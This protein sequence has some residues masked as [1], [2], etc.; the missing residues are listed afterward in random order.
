VDSKSG[1]AGENPWNATGWPSLDAATLR[2]G[3]RLRDLVVEPGR[4]TIGC[5]AN[6]IFRSPDNATLYLGTAA[7][8]LSAFKVGDP[9][10]IE[11][12]GVTGQVAYNS[13][14]TLAQTNDP[15]TATASNNDFALIRVDESHRHLVHP[16]L[17]H[18]GG[19]TGLAEAEDA[20]RG[21]AVAMYGNSPLWGDS[22]DRRRHEGCVLEARE[23]NTY[24][25]LAPVAV[26]GDSG[27]PALLATGE[28]LGLLTYAGPNDEGLTPKPQAAT[29]T[30]TNL[31]AALR[32]AR[33][34]AGLEVELATWPLLAPP[35][36]TPVPC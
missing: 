24:V 2:P 26:Q 7:H 29:N 17:L 35:G 28:A 33:E 1:G 19:P 15:G 27:G 3:V 25:R 9:I 5:S 8:C 20:P 30:L 21:T 16:A 4:V 13:F 36:G 31:A 32:F 11:G 34:K 12:A 22:E 6:F 18:Y 14:E 10:L 23:W